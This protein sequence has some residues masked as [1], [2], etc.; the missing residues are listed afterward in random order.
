MFGLFVM[1]STSVSTPEHWTSKP[2]VAGSIFSLPGV[3]TFRDIITSFLTTHK[4]LRT[5]KK[6]CRALQLPVHFH[7]MDI[8][9]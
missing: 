3:D 5:N 6:Y 7:Y 1:L 8:N 2:K 9:S 4:Y